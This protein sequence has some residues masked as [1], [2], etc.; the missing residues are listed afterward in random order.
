MPLIQFNCQLLKQAKDVI[1]AVAGTELEYSA[2]V[3]PH[4]RHV[5]EHYQLLFAGLENGVVDYECRVRGGE[6][7]SNPEATLAAIADIETA[8]IQRPL[9]LD[10]PIQAEFA[11]G[12]IGEEQISAQSS[13]GRELLFVGSHAIHHYAFIALA[14]KQANVQLPDGFGVAPGTR[15]YTTSAKNTASAA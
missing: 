9:P 3:G 2:T 6:I 14:L 13:L 1:H 8:L 4:L 11:V 7:E 12:M 10:A 15:R 5:I